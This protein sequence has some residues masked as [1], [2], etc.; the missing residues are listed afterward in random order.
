M[1]HNMSLLSVGGFDFRAKKPLDDRT[2]IYKK[3]W[4]QEKKDVVYY[5]LA[6]VEEV[7]PLARMADSFGPCIAPITPQGKGFQEYIVPDPATQPELWERH[8]AKMGTKLERQS[9][10][11]AAVG[12]DISFLRGGVMPAFRQK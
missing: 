1:W 8:V 2:A 5:H 11:L 9:A 6:G 4:S 12:Y 3:G 7:I 10:H